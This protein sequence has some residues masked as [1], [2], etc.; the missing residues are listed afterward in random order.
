MSKVKSPLMTSIL[1]AAH[2]DSW[3][4]SL[5]PQASGSKVHSSAPANASGDPFKVL[6]CTHRRD[7]HV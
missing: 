5:S 2:M 7:T 4:A 6:G 1:T 3:C